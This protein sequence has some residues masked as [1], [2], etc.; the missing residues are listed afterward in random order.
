[1]T[2][3]PLRLV[4][5]LAPAHKRALVFCDQ[6]TFGFGKTQP[7]IEWAGIKRKAD[8]TTEALDVKLHVTDYEIQRA[9][10]DAIAVNGFTR[11]DWANALPKTHALTLIH[12]FIASTTVV[13]FSL[14]GD[15]RRLEA[16]FDCSEI[17]TVRRWVEPLEMT[18]LLRAKHP[19]W[20]SWTLDTACQRYGIEGEGV[21]R[22]LGGATR[23]M[24]CFDKLMEELK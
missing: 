4:R 18:V 17:P 9:E 22:A 8:G 16:E 13:G 7:L 24:Q 1:M 6:E 12:N 23:A 21:H 5:G 19:T 10:P 11:E 20:G 14:D 15:L 3:P 2:C